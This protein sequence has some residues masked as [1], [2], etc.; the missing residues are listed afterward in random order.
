MSNLRQL[1]KPSQEI[2]DFE[3]ETT[4]YSVKIL[5]AHLQHIIEEKQKNLDNLKSENQWL[6]E[7]LDLEIEQGFEVYIPSPPEV[8]L[9][10]VIGFI[11]TV[12]GT[13]VEAQSISAPWGWDNQGITITTLGVTYQIGAVLLTG[14]LGGRNAAVLSQIAYI[15][16][17]LVGVP[18]FAH[19][20]GWQYILEPNFGYLLGFVFG[21]WLCG[22]L[23][24]K[25]LAQINSLFFSCIVGLVVIHLTGIVYLIFLSYWHGLAEGMSLPQGIYFYSFTPL[26][27]QLAVV[28]AVTLI[29]WIMRKIMFA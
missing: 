28:C 5:I 20:G 9:W 18:I 19:G 8:I 17:G 15:T 10:A 14:C 12:G 4:P 22:Y 21:A 1:P 24:F 16:I 2:T 13:F 26:L 6:R 29:S 27:G 23:A 7:Q 25:N 11:L 3:W